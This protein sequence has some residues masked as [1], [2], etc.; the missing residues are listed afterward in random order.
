MTAVELVEGFI[1]FEQGHGSLEDTCDRVRRTLA[2][3]QRE[4]AYGD[5]TSIDSICSAWFTTNEVVFESDVQMS[6]MYITAMI[7]MCTFPPLYLTFFCMAQY[8]SGY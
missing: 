3:T 6:I 4:C 8:P 5:Y 7:M 1:H 2:R